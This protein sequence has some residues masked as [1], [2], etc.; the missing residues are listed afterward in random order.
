MKKKRYDTAKL[1]NILLISRGNKLFFKDSKTLSHLGGLST[2]LV[3]P[4]AKVPR[5]GFKRMIKDFQKMLS[6]KGILKIIKKMFLGQ[7][8]TNI[9]Y[10]KRDVADYFT[11]ILR[12]L[13]NDQPFNEK[14][15]I[16]DLDVMKKIQYA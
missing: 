10:D 16:N 14:L 9:N 11:G 13:F 4:L 2:L 7:R 6:K 1:V 8:Y 5:K 15:I 12:A 3:G